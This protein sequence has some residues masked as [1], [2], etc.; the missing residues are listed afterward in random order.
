MDINVNMT[1][2]ILFCVQDISPSTKVQRER[3]SK[4]YQSPIELE[5]FSEEDR[6]LNFRGVV[7]G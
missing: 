5:E 3:L 7:I 1:A 4:F 2:S 6:S